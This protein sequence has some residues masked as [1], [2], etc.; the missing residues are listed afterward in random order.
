[1]KGTATFYSKIQTIYTAIISVLVPSF[2]ADPLESTQGKWLLNVAWR[3]F[4]AE[5]VQVEVVG[6]AVPPADFHFYSDRV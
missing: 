6:M 5:I 2:G 4:L 1:V 3:K